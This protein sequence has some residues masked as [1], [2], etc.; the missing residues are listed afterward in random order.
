MILPKPVSIEWAD[1]DTDVVQPRGRLLLVSYYFP[2]AAGV[3]STRVAK[4]AKYLSRRGWDV[5]ALTAE[6]QG[7]PDESLARDVQNIDTRVVEES[8][9]L[10]T[11]H[12]VAWTAALLPVLRREA[13][14]SDVVLVSGA[15]FLPLVAAALTRRRVP[16]VADLRD[17]WAAEPR[18]GRTRPGLR[19][20]I[21]RQAEQ[22]AEHFALQ[23]AAAVVTVAP[24][25]AEILTRAHPSL[26]GR[27]EVV[28]HG[29][30][31]DDVPA[32]VGTPGDALPVLLHTGTMIAGE[33]TPALVV[34]TAR[35]V[36]RAGVPLTVRLLGSFDERL[37]DMVDGPV[38]EGWLTVEQPVDHAQAVAAAA[39]AH[40]LWLEPGPYDFAI[41][42][43]VYEYIASGRPVVVAAPPSNAAAKLVARAGGGV[44]A[45]GSAGGCAVA[46]RNALAGDVPT[47]NLEV[48]ESLSLPH[49][50]EQLDTLLKGVVR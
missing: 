16:Y 30:D 25:L 47:R 22:F 45:G 10:P 27:V 15:P 46:V 34:E 41:T 3:A 37:R 32:A 7:V 36:R 19:R 1:Y 48:I 2:P 49:I 33:R 40:V 28:P 43:K 42:G 31:P 23:H 24:E 29:F 21:G 35:N 4:L 9:G 50:A 38:A 20:R 17:L 12:G 26:A 5:R 6:T 13:A 44:S 39:S 14:T 18:F 8:R 11:R